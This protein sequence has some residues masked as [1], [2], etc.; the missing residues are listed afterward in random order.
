MK[1]LLSGI[2]SLALV[3]PYCIPAKAAPANTQQN[4][5]PKVT[6]EL[7]VTDE[8]RAIIHAEVDDLSGYIGD[9]KVGDGRYDPYSLI[10][11]LATG[12]DYDSISYGSSAAGSIPSEYPFAVPDTEANNNEHSRKVEK[13]DWVEELA[14]ALG[15][16]VVVQR[17]DDKYVYIEIGDPD[18]PEMVMALSHLDSPTASN[19]ETQLERWRNADRE[20][21]ESD[22]YHTPYVQDGWLYGAGVQDD[23]GPTLATLFAAK[24]LMESGLSMDRRIR[25]VMGCYED[26]NPGVPTEEDTL[27]YMNIPYYTSNP[28]FYDNW[29]YKYLNREEMPIAAYT[30]D[31][32]FPVVVGNSKAITPTISMDLSKDAGQAFSLISAGANVTLREGDETLKYIVYGSTS[33]V[34]SRAVFTLQADKDTAKNQAFVDAVT[35]AATKLGWLPTA[36]GATPKVSVEVK[37]DTIVLETNTDV[38]MEMPT[39]QYGKNAV[40]WGM[41]LIAQGL[42]DDSQLQLKKAAD[43]ISDLFFQDCVEGEAYIGRYMGIPEDLLRNPDSG[44]ANLTFALMGGIQNT[45]DLVSFFEDN[46][47]S[48]PL[49]IRSMHTNETDYNTAM[50]AAVKAFHSKGFTWQVSGMEEG[51]YTTYSDPT[52][53]AS[54]DNPLIALQYASYK[55]TMESDPDAFEDVYGLLDIT[56]PV[57]TTGGTLASNYLNKMTAFGAVIPGNER[58]WHSA[59]ERI[60]VDAIVE[61]TKLMADGM[62]EMA[63]YSGPAGAQLMWAD[64]DG[65]NADRADLDLLDVTVGTYQD[66]STDVNAENLEGD[67]MLAATKF[68][69]PM[70]A[71]R[72][73]SSKTDAQFESGAVYLSTEDKDFLANT[74]VLP[75][76]LEFKVEKPDSMSQADWNALAASGLAGFTFYIQKD[77]KEIPL[78]VP[79]GQDASKFF[80]ARV[81]SSDPDIIYASVNLAITDAAYDGVTTVLADS[82]TDLYDLNDEWL[83]TNEDPFPERGEV[84]ERGFFLFGDG[85][86]DA[87]FTSP[88]AI[89]V[90]AGQ[91]DVEV[92]E[93]A[94]LY[95]VDEEGNLEYNVTYEAPLSGGVVV[96]DESGS[97]IDSLAELKEVMGEADA[98]KMELTTDPGARTLGDAVTADLTLGEDGTVVAITVTDVSERPI[99]GI[100]WKSDTIGSDYQGFAEAYERNGAIA[101]YLPQVHNAQEAREVLS[102]IDGIFFTGGEDWNPSLYEQTQ[103]PHGASGWNDARDTSD[104]NLMQQAVDMDVPLLA[105]CRGEQGFNIAMGGG[106]IQDVP[107]YLGQQVL[108]GEI[109][110]ERVTGILSGPSEADLQ[111]LMET[112][113]YKTEEELPEIFQTSVQDTGYTMYDDEGKYLGSSYNKDSN[114]YA[115]FDEGCEEGH[116]RVQVDGLIH[117]GGTKYHALAGGESND[118]VAISQDSKWLY[119]IVGDDSIDLVATAHHQSADPENLGDGLTVVARSSDGIIE[120]LEY[121]DATFALAL[122]WHPERDALGGTDSEELGVDVDLCNAFLRAL[123]TY[124]GGGEEDPGDNEPGSGGSSSSGDYLITAD[125]TSGGKVTVSP[126]RADKGDTVTITVKPNEGYELDKLTVTDQS[127]STVKVSDKGDNKYT[128]TMPGSRIT[129]EASFVKSE[130]AGTQD[131]PFADVPENAWYYDAVAYAVEKGIMD[132]VSSNLFQPNATLTRAQLA[133]ML[134]ALEGTPS[135]VSG[136][137][138]TDVAKDA[139]YADA[140]NWA[141]ANQVVSGYGDGTFGPDDVLSREQLCA[142]L[143]AYAKSEGRDV[144]G[145]TDLGKFSDSSSISTW[146]AQAVNWAVNDGL[147]SGM[148]DGTLAPSGTATRAQIAQIMQN[149]CEKVL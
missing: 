146:A 5:Q 113:G 108:N 106:L 80:A 12:S 135:A 103:S 32:R 117:S 33:Q 143:Y 42:G 137:S 30:S 56:Y 52:L 55:A 38:A 121:Q 40:V 22:S 16:P 141:A 51:K 70:W 10:G 122:Q 26:S 49:Y 47:L 8:E 25:I 41:Y 92:T 18:A 98:P 36:E 119:D 142:I 45:E 3:I 6:Y 94:I 68:D 125:N 61:M 79:E 128:F 100:S 127:G 97:G 149:F 74:F 66:A 114:S 59:N 83:E 31:S 133:Q 14:E 73:N 96:T 140:V 69:I 91:T 120:A 13:L 132:G 58:W 9:M 62:L 7:S 134:Y 63:R 99:V 48:I 138:F 144:S 28:S 65:L 90:T 23:S 82:K 39:P 111:K 116:L 44:V 43:G 27:A 139:W 129:V 118:D 75:M 88:D 34:A 87:R 77:G 89:Y 64:I 46:S 11:G 15:F 53:Y 84:E 95:T 101:V 67:T 71:E 110:P 19:N 35:A 57:G 112:W 124:A 54:H 105:V 131:L 50:D 76:R 1:K 21:G 20:Y 123:V 93:D 147:V 145:Q 81:S 29:A 109:D 60:G 102:H 126:G 2:L 148:A 107:Y 78:T 17:Q 104:I 86:K 37:D 130:D 85:E 136:T 4:F 115:E 72:G 24:A